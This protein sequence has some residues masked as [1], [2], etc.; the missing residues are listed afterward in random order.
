MIDSMGRMNIKEIIMLPLVGLLIGIVIF[1]SVGSINQEISIVY[2]DVEKQII[3]PKVE[4]AINI[5]AQEAYALIQNNKDGQNFMILDVRTPEEIANGYIE[6]SISIDY[7]SETFLEQIDE[8]DKNKTYLV[9][10]KVGG[11][12]GMAMDLMGELGFQKI[13]NMLGGFDQWE[14]EGL[15]IVK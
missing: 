13:Y 15:P 4:R 6:N 5:T 3:E 10:C 2:H 12:S 9:Y 14:A 11:R 8:L 7:Y 1:A